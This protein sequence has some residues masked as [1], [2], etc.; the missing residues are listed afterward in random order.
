MGFPWDFPWVIGIP[1]SGL[2]PP[3]TGLG[4]A[5]ILDIHSRPVA[6]S[7]GHGVFMGFSMG[8]CYPL[9]GLK[10]P[11]TGLGFASALDIHSRP[12]AWSLGHGVLVIVTL[13][14]G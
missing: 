10:P 13:S 2:K 4:F 9:S 7:L 11:T 6:W 1:F 3:T 12:V 8:Y 5:S 14:R